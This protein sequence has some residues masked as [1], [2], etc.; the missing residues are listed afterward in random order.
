MAICHPL[1]ACNWL[2]N[3][4]PRI[5]L[6]ANFTSKSVFDQQG[7]RALARLSCSVVLPLQQCGCGWR[8]LTQR[9][10]IDGRLFCS[11]GYYWAD[12]D[13]ALY[14]VHWG[15]L[16]RAACCTCSEHLQPK[17]RPVYTCELWPVVLSWTMFSKHTCY[18][19]ICTFS[20]FQ[21]FSMI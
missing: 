10:R 2:Q 13:N 6:S 19:A 16:A 3:E 7:C 17:Q 21:A 14:C 20:S 1:S 12:V 18:L 15:T 9:Y 11:F 4:W 8:L 5:T